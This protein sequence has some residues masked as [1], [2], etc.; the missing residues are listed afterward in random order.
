M[1]I[2]YTKVT[3]QGTQ[4]KFQDANGNWTK[5]DF[6]GYEGAS[7][8][9]ASELLKASSPYAFA[10][11]K[12]TVFDGMTGCISPSF[13]GEGEFIV[14]AWKLITQ[15]DQEQAIRKQRWGVSLEERAKRLVDFVEVKTGIV[16][17]GQYLT[18]T[19]ELDSII[20]NEDRHLGNVCVLRKAEGYGLCPIFDNGLSLLSDTSA[21]PFSTDTVHLLQEAKAMPFDS[22]FEKQVKAVGELYGSQLK[23][24]T[25]KL[26]FASMRAAISEVYQD[27]RVLRCVDALERQLEAHPEYCYDD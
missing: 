20:R 13:L 3:S 17:F 25:S 23:I 21:H 19:I 16:N 18:F 14:T 2:N 1:G 26:N 4:A 24:N 27:R 6:Y 10:V 15:Y 9:V 5:V 22:S 11:Y 7:E 8:F 12:P